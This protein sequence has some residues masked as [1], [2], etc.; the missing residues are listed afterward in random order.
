MKTKR[1]MKFV[2]KNKNC[3][4]SDLAKNIIVEKKEDKWIIKSENG[5]TVL[6]DPKSN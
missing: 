2:Q 3:N 5:S 4:F 6:N 1:L